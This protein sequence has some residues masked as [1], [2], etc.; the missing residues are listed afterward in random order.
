MVENKDL[1]IFHLEEPKEELDF[2]FFVSVWTLALT[3]Y[4]PCYRS[5]GVEFPLCTVVIVV[6]LS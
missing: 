5:V 2:Q 1:E 6:T 3:I 4:A